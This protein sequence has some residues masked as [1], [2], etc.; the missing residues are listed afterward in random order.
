M[1]IYVTGVASVLQD[2][3]DAGNYDLLI[4]GIA[5]LCVVLI[6]MLII[7]RSLVAALLIVGTVV[8]SLGSAFGLSVLVWQYIIGINL[9][10]M[11]LL[12]SVIILLAVGADYNLLLVSRMKEEIGGRVEDGHYPCNGWDRQSRDPRGFSVR[13]HD[14]LFL[15]SATCWWSARL[16][17]LSALGLL[18]DTLVVRAFL[19]PSVAAMLK[20][21]F[22]WPMKVRTRAIPRQTSILLQVGRAAEESASAEFPQRCRRKGIPLASWRHRD[23]R[24][25]SMTIRGD[26]PPRKQS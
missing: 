20:C 9:H 21:R 1:S 19:M 11:V 4:A 16:A 2:L 17:R 23:Q 7:T 12:M 10:W 14:G 6:V 8:V 25:W 13:I 18:F 24:K 15:W 5:S 26:F 22:W 3:Q